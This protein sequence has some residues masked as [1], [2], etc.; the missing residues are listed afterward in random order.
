M[1]KIMANAFIPLVDSYSGSFFIHYVL[2][3]VSLHLLVIGNKVRTGKYI[4]NFIIT[5]INIICNKQ[6]YS[7]L[8]ISTLN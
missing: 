5:V 7:N 6:I 2:S 4:V 1:V 3:A 8:Y